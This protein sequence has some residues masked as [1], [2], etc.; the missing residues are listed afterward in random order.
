MKVRHKF[1]NCE[2]CDFRF[3][4]ANEFCPSC[5]QE[6]HTHKLPFRYFLLEYLGSIYNFDTKVLR[7]L[8]GMFVNPGE[9]IALFNQNKR[10][11]FV[12]PVRMFLF[13]SFLL[14]LMIG[15]LGTEDDSTKLADNKPITKQDSTRIGKTF[16]GTEDDSTKLADNKPITKQDSTGNGVEEILFSIAWRVTNKIEK[17]CKNK[18]KKEISQTF[19]GKLNG[20]MILLLPVFSFFMFLL[21]WR[22]RL[23]YSEFFIFSLF[24]QSQICFIFSFY[25]ILSLITDGFLINLVLLTLPVYFTLSLKR[26]YQQSWIKTIIKALLFGGLAFFIGVIAVFITFLY[27]LYAV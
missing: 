19:L 1:K 18:S 26:V 9:T 5:G 23:F 6:N 27:A 12:P 17:N 4:K 24:F 21:Y 7:T 14:F 16:L 25:F 8:K 10:A 11:R 13:S 20:T 22:K 3:E 2:N 15:F